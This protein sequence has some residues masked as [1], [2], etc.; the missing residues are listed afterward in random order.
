MSD[1][2]R[3]PVIEQ[4]SP[5][6]SYRAHQP[7]I[8]AAITRVLEGGGYVLGEEVRHFEREL[9]AFL[10]ARRAVGVASG[11]D[12]IELALRG[13]GVGPG[14]VVFTVAHT[15][16][17]TVAA[18]ERAGAGAV[19]VDVDPAWH[20]LDPAAL[21][22]AARAA[23][24]RAARRAVLAVHLYGCPA[25]MNAILEVARRHELIVI[26]DCAQAAG[27][28]IAGRRVGTFGRAAAF[29]FY[30]TKNL[31]ALGDGGAVV[32]SD[33]TV[34]DR[35]GLLREYGWR[36]RQVSEIVGMNSR[37]D[38]VQAAVLRVKL[39]TLDADNES[40][41]ERARAYGA[42]LDGAGL[43]VPAVR[44]GTTHVFHQYVVR[45]PAR[46]GLRAYLQAH[47]II[48]NVHYPQPV[49]CQPAYRGRVRVCGDLAASER[50][51]AEVLSL[52]MYAELPMAD[53][54]ATAAAI[55][56]WARGAGST[57]T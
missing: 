39:Q 38:E 49:H 33:D 41:S 53:V 28:C 15:A 43:S 21:D 30:P 25:D 23:G 7:G 51:A 52:P 26:E 20:T 12:A 56:A 19:L 44:P 9:A 34:A 17:A 13:C 2:P 22:L 48:T 57:A 40:R 42:A 29:S 47:Q 55:R 36:E 50:A 16:V 35:V 32:S 37:L 18:I 10:G 27:A 6:A 54:R 5:L 24:G 8:Q 3:S 1:H 31:G 4:A 45:T 14:D 46:D 11:T